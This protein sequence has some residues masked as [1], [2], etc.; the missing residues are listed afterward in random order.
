MTIDE[1]VHALEICDSAID[2]CA[3]CAYFSADC[4]NLRPLR[5]DALHY[6]K[7]YQKLIDFSAALPDY[8]ELLEFWHEHHDVGYQKTVEM[9]IKPACIPDMENKPLTFEE[10][11]QMERK[12]VWIE[13]LK[14]D[15]WGYRDKGSWWL[16][17]EVRINDIIIAQYL[18]EAELCPEDLDVVWNAYRKERENE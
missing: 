16:V 14:Y 9:V 6:M 11:K 12:P 15:I 4:E 17:G 3:S 13:W 10:L 8:Y 5:A 1:V 18:D 7:E 2:D